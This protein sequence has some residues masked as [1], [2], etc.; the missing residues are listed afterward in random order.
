MKSIKIAALIIGAIALFPAAS[1]AENVSGS[2]QDANLESTTVGNG[3]VTLTETKQNILNL[4]KS[5]R[6]D[7]NVSG[8]A[9]RVNASTTTVGDSNVSVKKAIQD[10]LSGQKAK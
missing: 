2:T 7:T 10:A 1:F 4:Q 6:Y 8:T 3:N 9:Q 5:G